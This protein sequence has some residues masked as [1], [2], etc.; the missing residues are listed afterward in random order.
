VAKKEK[1]RPGCKSNTQGGGGGLPW[2]GEEANG[3]GKRCWFGVKTAGP[4][5]F[6]REENLGLKAQN[7]LLT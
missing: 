3:G 7:V 4:K 1:R 2:D 5:K 6:Q